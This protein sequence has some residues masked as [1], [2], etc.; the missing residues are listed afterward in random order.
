MSS[1]EASLSSNSVYPTLLCHL[2]IAP[3]KQAMYAILRDH[4]QNSTHH[5]SDCEALKRLQHHPL[6]DHATDTET[7]LSSKRVQTFILLTAPTDFFADLSTDQFHF[8][9]K[10]STLLEYKKC[11]T[12][13]QRSISQF[14][15]RREKFICDTQGLYGTVEDRA[16]LFS[17][18]IVRLKS[19]FTEPEDHEISYTGW[20]K[21]NQDG[22]SHS[23]DNDEDTRSSQQK[24]P[25]RSKRTIKEK[26][27]A[28]KRSKRTISKEKTEV[29]KFWRKQ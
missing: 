10:Q 2:M 8:F 11:F 18:I 1:T 13:N 7:S 17:S 5:K 3:V 15:I 9:M 19:G 24:A 21:L 27:K 4:K 23:T 25:K 20:K 29:S 16:D 6:P 14:F 22:R 12:L 28:P 26:T